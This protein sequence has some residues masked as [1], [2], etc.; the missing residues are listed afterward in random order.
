MD[1]PT[2][3]LCYPDPIIGLIG[4]SL[5]TKW[6]SGQRLPAGQASSRYSGLR[7]GRL[8]ALTESPLLQTARRAGLG[9]SWANRGQVAAFGQ[10]AN[11]RSGVAAEL[12]AAIVRNRP[13]SRRAPRGHS[14][15]LGGEAGKCENGQKTDSTA[16]RAGLVP[17]RGFWVACK[18]HF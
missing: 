17:E 4:I 11:P 2:I 16:R 6:V 12:G 7:T 3:M 15:H 13:D 5:P 8:A 18:T 9:S 14:Q 1:Y 10:Y